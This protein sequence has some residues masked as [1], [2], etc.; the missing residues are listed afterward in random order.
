MNP[1]NP[2]SLMAA[3]LEP[4]F[5]HNV[6]YKRQLICDVLSPAGLAG[7]WAGEW[8]DGRA[9]AAA[10]FKAARQ[11]NHSIHRTLHRRLVSL[12]LYLPKL[13]FLIYVI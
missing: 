1:G 2:A 11:G 9:A 5:F 6:E 13:I 4:V 3:A 12:Y 10:A 7:G 8:D